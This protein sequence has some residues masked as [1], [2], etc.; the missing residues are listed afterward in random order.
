MD[1]IGNGSHGNGSCA[2]RIGMGIGNGSLGNAMGMGAMPA[3]L[4]QEVGMAV[5]GMGTM[6]AGLGQEQEKRR[7]NG[8][9]MGMWNHTRAQLY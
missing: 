5:T 7:V 1:R 4:G 6:P 9:E 3:G 8:T 2:C